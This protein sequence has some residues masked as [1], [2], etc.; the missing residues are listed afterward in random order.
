MFWFMFYVGAELLIL[1]TIIVIRITSLSQ[2]Y[3]VSNIA[4]NIGCRIKTICIV[5]HYE[6]TTGMVMLDVHFEP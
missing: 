2:S 3:F 1:V 6:S 5:P 4:T